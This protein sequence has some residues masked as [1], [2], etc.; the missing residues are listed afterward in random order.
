MDIT[1]ALKDN[2]EAFMYMPP[3]MQEKA[4]GIGRSSFLYLDCNGHYSDIGNVSDEADFSKGI[5]YRLRPDYEESGVVELVVEEGDGRLFFTNK[6]G[7]CILC[8]A[9]KYVDFIG[10]KYES[11]MTD[12]VPR[13]YRTEAD[14][15]TKYKTGILTDE[16]DEWEVLTPTHVL[17]GRSK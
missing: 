6:E 4:K 12:T 3:E 17:F 9:S 16:V 8:D 5:V 7:S 13:L 14:G 2:K 1:K 11:N 10:F 15:V